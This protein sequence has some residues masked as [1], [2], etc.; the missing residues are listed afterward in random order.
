MHAEERDVAGDDA[1]RIDLAHVARERLAQGFAPGGFGP[2][3]RVWR[4]LLRLFAMKLAPHAAQQTETIAARA[5]D[6]RLMHIGRTDP[7]SGDANDPTL[8]LREGR[9]LRS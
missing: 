9:N 4:R 8:S 3:R 5:P 7:G 2:V 1:R 6:A